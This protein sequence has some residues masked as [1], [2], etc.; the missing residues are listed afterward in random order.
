M[1]TRTDMRPIRWWVLFSPQM[2]TLPQS[3][4]STIFFM[5]DSCCTVLSIH[6]LLPWISWCYLFSWEKKKKKKVHQLTASMI[7]ARVFWQ[8]GVLYHVGS[9]WWH[10]ALLLP[11]KLNSPHCVCAASFQQAIAQLYSLVYIIVRMIGNE[12]IFRVF[13]GTEKT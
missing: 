4:K 10:G 9:M 3:C 13:V 6:P 2:S 11:K 7:Q 1:K 8:F 12:F 5:L